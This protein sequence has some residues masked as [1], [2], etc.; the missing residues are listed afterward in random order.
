MVVHAYYPLAEPRVQREAHAARDA[1]FDVTVISLRRPGERRDEVI[2]DI[3]VHRFG[4]GHRRGAG[5]GRMVFEYLMFCAVATPWL[6]ARSV[7]RP[8]G[9]V[10]F[11]NPPDFVVAAGLF[12]RA[13]GS[14]LILDIHDLSSHMLAV[15]VPGRAG[16]IASRCLLWIER[17][18]CALVDIVITVHEPYREELVRHGI[19]RS[20]IS[21][22]MNAVDDAVIERSRATHRLVER[23]AAFRVAYHGTLTAWYGTDLVVEAIA[24][25]RATGVD[26]DAVIVGGGDA[27]PALR[28]QVSAAGLQRSVHLF[29]EYVPIEQALA[30]VAVADCGVIPNRRSE[31]N[32]F[33]LSSKLFEYVALGVPV[34]VSELETLANHFGPQEVTFFEPGN[35]ASLVNALGWVYAHREEAAE[36]AGRARARAAQY[37][38]GR[39]RDELLRVYHGLV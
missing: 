18:S 22:V 31:I 7:R 28:A 14:K 36:K 21:V 35:V 16:T 11:H 1:G 24:A 2:D 13:R 19:P 26:A 23:S 3:R 25:L 34:V 15:R 29:G 30:T 38:W 32:R 10:H 4:L 8:F 17:A 5:L 39:S 37:S 12:A 20:K 6:A 27:V 33:A 9:I